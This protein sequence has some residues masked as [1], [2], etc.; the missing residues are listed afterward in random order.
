MSGFLAALKDIWRLA[1]PYFTRRDMAEIE[2]WGL[3]R[4]RMQER[5]FA[6]FLLAAVVGLE[7]VF[8][9]I[10][11]RFNAWYNDFYKA[12]QNKNYDAFL[13]SLKLFTIIA[14]GHILVGVYKTYVNQWLQIR[15]RRS[16]TA[17][18]IARWLQPA[19]HYRMQL[20]GSPADNPDQRISEDVHDFV[21]STMSLGIGFFGNAVR[22]AIFI[23]VL[24]GLSETFPMQSFGFSYNIPGYLVWVSLAYALAGTMI[25]HLIGRALV[26]IEFRRQRYEADFRFAMARLRENSEQVALLQ[27]EARERGNLLDRYAYVFAIAV[28]RI[29]R[30]KKLSWFTS[31]FAQFSVIFPFLMLGPAYF[32]GSADLGDMMQTASTFGS[33]QDGMTWFVDSYMSLAAYRANVTRLTG[34]EAAATAADR[35]LAAT[36]HIA[37]SPA[38]GPAFTAS[39]LL[40]TRPPASPSPRPPS[41]RWRPASASS[42][43]AH[44]AR[45]RRR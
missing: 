15:W 10:A 26:A 40:V 37:T 23:G 16:M 22:L 9:F 12:L 29:K 31:F 44:R 13:G 30:V 43:T 45:A 4:V 18:Y 5:Q 35:A 21:G 24:W 14:I 11:K 17:S 1:L 7:I 2:I 39:H 20:L 36:P 41:S 34:F 42:S 25:T 28:E 6:W 32:F 27:G 3:G 8:S 19:Q 33:V 38:A